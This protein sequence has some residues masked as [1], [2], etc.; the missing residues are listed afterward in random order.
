M[1]EVRA[2]RNGWRDEGLSRRHRRWGWN[3]PAVDLDCVFLEYDKAKAVAIVEYK[4]ESAEPL[5]PS[6]PSALALRDLGD[7]ANLPVFVVRY[8]KDYSR[9]KVQPMNK[10]AKLVQAD[11]IEM[12]EKQYITFLHALRGYDI[13]QD[14]LDQPDF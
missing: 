11:R 5:M 12:T 14:V 13:P 7:R 10:I 8:A 4:C 3:C 6:H 1:P 2:E 9:Y